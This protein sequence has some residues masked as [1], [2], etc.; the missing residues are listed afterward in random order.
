MH[1]HKIE[2]L[3]TYLKD[4]TKTKVNNKLSWLNVTFSKL[5]EHIFKNQREFESE[6]CQFCETRSKDYENN[7]SA[8]IVLMII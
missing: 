7:I 1:P 4:S 3:K 6:N 5:T 2:K 8:T